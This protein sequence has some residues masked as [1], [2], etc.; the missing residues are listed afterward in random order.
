MARAATAPLPLLSCLFLASHLGCDPNRGEGTPTPGVTQ[1]APSVDT[2]CRSEWQTYSL[3]L[4]SIAEVQERG[5]VMDLKLEGELWL[6]CVSG[7]K[8][9]RTQLWVTLQDSRVLLGGQPSPAAQAI[10][11]PLQHA[12][13]VQAQDGRIVDSWFHESLSPHAISIWR[14]IFGALQFSETSPPAKKWSAEEYDSTGRYQADYA[15]ESGRIVRRKSRYLA[16]LQQGLNLET[17]QTTMPRVVSSETVFTLGEG[18]ISS[19]RLSEKVSTPV[20][21]AREM[22]VTTKVTLTRSPAQ[23]KRPSLQPKWSVDGPTF[24]HFPPDKSGPAPV[25]DQASQFDEAK[26]QGWTVDRAL[27]A[28]LAPAPKGAAEDDPSGSQAFPALTAFFRSRPETIDHLARNLRQDDKRNQIIVSALGS[29]GTERATATLIG[30]VQDSAADNSLRSRAIIKLTHAL[31]PRPEVIPALTPL[32]DDPSL[33]VQALMGLGAVSRQFRDQGR[34]SHVVEV[35]RVLETRL[36]SAR[37][38]TNITKVLQAI[39][40]SGDDLLLPSVR[41]FLKHAS[42]RVRASAAVAT[43]HMKSPEAAKIMAHALE[44]ESEKGDLL[45]I[46][47]GALT[48]GDSPELHA[49]VAAVAARSGL[50]REVTSRA[51]GIV[52]AWRKARSDQN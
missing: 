46:L 25:R 47:S 44:T 3:G 5:P 32:V 4:S 34:E 19:I 33:G 9:E 7:K 1:Q 22:S 41:P 18:G 38:V 49:A 29:A 14:T 30:V 17:L 36:A 26:M 10:G 51:Q 37:G 11:A 23:G 24:L 43:S 27:Q 45:L 40:N 39:A 28:L 52:D 6:R 20:E 31:V 12:V 35:R 48:H 50:D 13:A 21:K 2:W 15:L 42:G 8:E 16:L